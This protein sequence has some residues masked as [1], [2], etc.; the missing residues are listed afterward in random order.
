MRI[1]YM[2]IDETVGISS[3]GDSQTGN[4]DWMGLLGINGYVAFSDNNDHFNPLVNP[5][6][7]G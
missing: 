6:T 3:V 5:Q 2:F 4:I 7:L 1:E